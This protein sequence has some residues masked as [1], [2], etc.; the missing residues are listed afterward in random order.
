MLAEHPDVLVR[1]RDEILETVG[2]HGKVSPESLREMKYL[3][4]VF[5]G[6]WFTM[7]RHSS[8]L[9]CHRDAEI[10]SKPVRITIRP[11]VYNLAEKRTQSME[12]QMLQERN[13][14]ASS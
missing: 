1:L 14:M 5:D 9:T 7:A 8:H 6:K 3:R 12:H 11:C 4:A 13:G 2:P 10:V